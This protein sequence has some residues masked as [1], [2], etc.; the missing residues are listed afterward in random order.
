MMNNINLL[1]RLA[2]SGFPQEGGGEYINKEERKYYSPLTDELIAELYISI[3]SLFSFI[4]SSG[5][6]PLKQCKDCNV[7]FV[8]KKHHGKGLC[9]K[10]YMRLLRNKDCGD[11]SPQ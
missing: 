1:K 3:D 2:E 8:R 11:N 5:R 9:K 7:L 10:C 6:N 4:E